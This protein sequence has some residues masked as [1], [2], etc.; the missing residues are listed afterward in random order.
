[1]GV[2]PRGFILI[3]SGR[4]SPVSDPQNNAVIWRLSSIPFTSTH[5]DPCFSIVHFDEGTMLRSVWSQLRINS[6][7]MF[8]IVTVIFKSSRKSAL[9]SSKSSTS[10]HLLVVPFRFT[11]PIL[12]ISAFAQSF[13]KSIC[14]PNSVS[15]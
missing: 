12:V 10:L 8:S 6:G 3:C 2:T 4:K 14:P 15:K 5:F 7:G 1:M 9:S 11:Y 13:V